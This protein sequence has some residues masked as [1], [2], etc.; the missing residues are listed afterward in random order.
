MDWPVTIHEFEQRRTVVMERQSLATASV[1]SEFVEALM[2]SERKISKELG[3]AGIMT[4]HRGNQAAAKKANAQQG[5]SKSKAERSKKKQ[6]VKKSQKPDENPNKKARLP[7]PDFKCFPI[8]IEHVCCTG[9][10]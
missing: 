4:A 8:N 10:W 9:R 1:A 5:D 2:R 6:N 7:L 3:S